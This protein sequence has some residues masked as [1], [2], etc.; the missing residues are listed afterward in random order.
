MRLSFRHFL[1][2]LTGLVLLLPSSAVAHTDRMTIDVYLNSG[3]ENVNTFS[4]VLHY[5]AAWSVEKI[6][7]KNSPLIYWIDPPGV[8]VFGS[9]HF[10]G[11]IPGGVQNLGAVDSEKLLY[12]I[13][14]VGQDEAT[15][16]GDVFFDDEE[17][18]LNHPAALAATQTSFT[19]SYRATDTYGSFDLPTTLMDLSFSFEED[20]ITGDP[21][22]VL[23]SYRGN[24]AAYSFWG[25]E[26]DFN[27]N[28]WISVDGVQVL[29]S[30]SSTVKL[31]VLD[32]EGGYHTLVLRRSPLRVSLFFVGIGLFL[33]MVFYLL[34]AP[35]KIF[36]SFPRAIIRK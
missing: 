15:L 3:E 4:G 30:S 33:C 34:R 10:S 29:E 28:D 35:S 8:D 1:I 2:S 13:D 6:R 19:Y 27:S 14:F 16:G 20:P 31:S 12:S 9:I 24:L 18:Y 11:A 7:L 25:R 21:A 36:R 17:F 5:P 23:D 22:L 26:G 32:D